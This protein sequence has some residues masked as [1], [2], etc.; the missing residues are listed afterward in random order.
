MRPSFSFSVSC[1]VWKVVWCGVLHSLEGKTDKQLDGV[2]CLGLPKNQVPP[3]K[4][5]NTFSTLPRPR[6]NLLD[7]LNDAHAS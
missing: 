6:Q 1:L 7:S 5:G 2:M 4:E 3:Q